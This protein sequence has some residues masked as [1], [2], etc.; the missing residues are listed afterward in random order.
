MASDAVRPGPRCSPTW[1]VEQ[2]VGFMRFPPL[3]T[4]NPLYGEVK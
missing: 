4:V 1:H 3:K 2:Q